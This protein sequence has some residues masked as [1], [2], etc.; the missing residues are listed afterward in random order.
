MK[1]TL[2]RLGLTTRRKQVY[3]FVRNQTDGADAET[4][5][6]INL[7]SFTKTSGTS[8]AAKDF[9]A[10]YHE[11]SLGDVVLKGQRNPRARLD[12]VPYDFNGKS[13]LDIGCN[14]GGMVFAVADRVKWAIG[15][16]YDYKMVNAC[17]RIKI[18][19]A[20][21]QLGFYVFDI[22]KDPQE[23]VL[24]FIPEANIDIVFLLSVCMWVKK[25]RPLI[26]LCRKTAPAMLFEANGTQDQQEEQLA[27]LATRYANL[28]V[29]AG[30]SEDDPGQKKRQLVL[31]S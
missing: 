31:A 17:N 10:G 15:L 7:L 30:T 27:Y 24:D 14:Q 20:Q 13:V 25:W 9:P 18:S 26:D 28:S 23:L 12:L 8:Y 5:R 11:I 21:N 1:D 4:A 29:L 6:I 16:D 2:R 22:D 19:R 3:K